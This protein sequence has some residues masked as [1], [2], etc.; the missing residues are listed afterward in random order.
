MKEVLSVWKEIL[1][2]IVLALLIFGSGFISGIIFK[3]N[4]SDNSEAGKHYREYQERLS[5]VIDGTTDIIQGTS[6]I[7]GTVAEIQRTDEDLGKS[8]DDT[9]NAVGKINEPIDSIG[10]SI[11]DFE[12]GLSDL[13][14][15]R[16]EMER[17]G[18]D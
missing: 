18:V 2:G 15:L 13:K 6:E 5:G 10:K 3:E 7:Q 4:G 1:L 12:S 14:E 9:A 11:G 17:A 8:I 16:A